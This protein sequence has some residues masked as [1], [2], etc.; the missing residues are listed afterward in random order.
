MWDSFY[1]RRRRLLQISYSRAGT[2]KK[3][4]KKIRRKTGPA[5]EQTDDDEEEKEE[6]GES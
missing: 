5:T 1:W 2:G 3:N 6:E 4:P